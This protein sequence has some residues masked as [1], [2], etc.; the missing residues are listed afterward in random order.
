MSRLTI[1]ATLIFL[2]GVLGVPV[3]SAAPVPDLT[4]D[5]PSAPILGEPFS[6]TATFQNTGTDPGYGPFID[7]VLQAT[8][9]DGDDGA[10]FVDAQ[11]LGVSLQATVQ[12]FALDTGCVRHPFARDIENNRLE[13]CGTPGDQLVTLRLPFGS[14]V[15]SQLPAEIDVTATVSPLADV[16]VGL[17]IRARA[18]FEFGADPLRNPCCDPVVVFPIEA[19]TSVWGGGAFTPG[20]VGA[21]KTSSAEERGTETSVGSNF[22]HQYTIAMN[23]PD[24][25]TINNFAV[26]DDL[27]NTLAFVSLDD[28]LVNGVST[29]AFTSTLPPVGTPQNPPNN[30]LSVTLDNPVTGTTAEED[31]VVVF[32]YF[33]AEVDANGNPTLDPTSAASRQIENTVTAAGNWTPGDPRDDAFAGELP[34]PVCGAAPLHAL[35]ARAMAV[36]K[37]SDVFIDSGATGPTPGDILQN[38][39]DFQLADTFTADLLEVE[40][41]FTDGLALY[42]GVPACTPSFSITDQ[43]G[44]VNGTFT[45]GNDLTITSPF[46]AQGDTQ[47]LFDVAQAL[48]NQ[49]DD[50]SIIG[51]DATPGGIGA[52]GTITYCTEILEDFVTYFP[53]GD[54]SVDLGDV[55]SNEADMSGQLQGVGEPSPIPVTTLDDAG[56]EVEI[57]RGT[58]AKVVYAVNGVT[59]GACL[60][61]TINPGDTV[62]YRLTY[63]LPTSDFDYLT[64]TDFLPIPIFDAAEVTTFDAIIDGTVPAPGTAKFGPADTFFNSNAPASAYTPTIVTDT[65]NNTVSFDYGSYDDTA[66]PSTTIDILFTVTVTTR[67]FADGLLLVNQL[68]ANETNTINETA[69][70]AAVT[71]VELLQPFLRVRKGVVGTDNPSSQIQPALPIDFTA[72]GDGGDPWS[73]I[74]NS[75]LLDGTDINS[76]V[77]NADNGDLIRFA[78]VIENVGH[79]D[80]GAFDII[81]RDVLE[82]GFAI[83]P[84]GI[85]L[86]VRRGDGTVMSFTGAELDLFNGGIELVDPN[87]GEGVCQTYD[88]TSGANIVILTYDLR[89]ETGTD[90]FGTLTNSAGVTQYASQ[91]GLGTVNNFVEDRQV[92][93]DG[94]DVNGDSPAPAVNIFDPA[95]SKI[96][97]LL[98]G[99]LG[100]AEEQVEWII[101][102][103]NPSGVT[104]YDVSIT[105]TLRPELRLDRVEISKGEASINGQ[106]ISVLIPVLEPGEVVT[107]N[108]FTTV[109]VGADRIGEI[110]NTVCA[111]ARDMVGEEC[112]TGQVIAN[113]PETG[114]PRE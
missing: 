72:P 47:L 95:I 9:A 52:T 75:Q 11:Y 77:F 85:N 102:I 88:L 18:G 2:L 92:Y 65:V 112:S 16:G 80:D 19:D 28:V 96:G 50:G 82:D 30:R 113:L 10:I 76:D 38:I 101:T 54:P 58:P 71:S 90:A 114:E 51:G 48:I 41:I 93:A 84:E 44:T 106:T 37:G 14:F 3:V 73:G 111:L 39:I 110:E 8:G 59:C 81:V 20:L 108:V 13:V 100:L 26:R 98:P 104:G 83:P 68:V 55:L 17:N 12:T 40:D 78:I 60:D 1:V 36:Q 21:S 86:Q 94:A 29:G 22:V 24:G 6:F 67:P 56:A 35:W 109:L 7:L 34:C 107:M 89:V 4:L 46:G 63:D 70:A 33:V 57:T 62:T 64:L 74:I 97:F 103:S 79:S 87:A 66:N 69:Q 27:A 5:I 99:D 91:D 43:T 49:G 32:S 15:P 42:T 53:S 45:I 61:Q 105:D 23:L 31:V 25:E